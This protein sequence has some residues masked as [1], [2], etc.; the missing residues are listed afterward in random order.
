MVP[1]HIEGLSCDTT[2][3]FWDCAL[4]LS[5]IFK[6]F[7]AI[8]HW[9]SPTPTP[10][11]AAQSFHCKCLL[12]SSEP[13]QW[14]LLQIA[15]VGRVATKHHISANSELLPSP[16]LSYAWCGKT[17][18]REGVCIRNVASD[19]FL[20]YSKQGQVLDWE[21]LPHFYPP[22]LSFVMN[23][24]SVMVPLLDSVSRMWDPVVYVQQLGFFGLSLRFPSAIVPK[25]LFLSFM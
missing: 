14:R 21:W 16:P 25:L 3:W 11:P 7:L 10:F 1:S 6:F 4:V 8:V 5:E 18:W 13:W 15:G 22:P 23:H 24:P 12:C 19:T 2:N 20:V 17:V 9:F